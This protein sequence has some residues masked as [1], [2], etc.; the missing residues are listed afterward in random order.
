MRHCGVLEELQFK[1]TILAPLSRFLIL[2]LFADVER[3]D[4]EAFGDVAFCFGLTE[5][6]AVVGIFTGGVTRRAGSLA[7][8]DIP[9]PEISVVVASGSE[10][11]VRELSS[12][13]EDEEGCIG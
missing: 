8:R 11:A 3:T 4:A 2:R 5:R 7:D 13:L 1:Q 10:A 6:R 9:G 12:E